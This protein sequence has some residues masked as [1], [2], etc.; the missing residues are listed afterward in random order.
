M[1]RK[2]VKTIGARTYRNYSSEN[3][4]KA[5]VAV[6][7]GRL[8]IRQASIQFGV[9]YGTIFNRKNGLHTLKNGGQAMLSEAEEKDLTET[10]QIAGEWGFPLTQIAIQM[11][12][13]DYMDKHNIPK[14]KPNSPGKDWYYGYMERH[15]H[16]LS[17]RQ[18]QNIKRSRAKVN[19]EIVNSYFDKL[20]VVLD[21]VPAENVVNYDETNFVDD[22]ES[23]KVVIK[24]RPKS[25]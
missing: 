16:D 17:L 1:P 21:G 24:K 4:Q 8:S 6:K 20:A 13:S 18:S 10:I 7:T 11:L 5:V 3:V 19:P 9:S 22:P 25:C 15:K 23:K 2:Y 12:V 14:N